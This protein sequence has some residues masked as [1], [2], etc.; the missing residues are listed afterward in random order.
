M[1]KTIAVASP[2]IAVDSPAIGMR[3]KIL[4]VISNRNLIAVTIFSTVGLLL[5]ILL[6]IYLPFRFP[7]LGA[8][9]EQY[10]Q[11]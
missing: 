8:L 11:F 10:S 4:A 5:A 7:S 6:T 9:I 1:S 3:D 2:A